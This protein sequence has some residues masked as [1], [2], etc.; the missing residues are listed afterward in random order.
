MNLDEFLGKQTR[1][2]SI[3]YCRIDLRSHR[4]DKTTNISTSYI[5]QTN[6]NN[7]CCKAH[8]NVGEIVKFIIS[9][10][11]FPTF[12]MSWK[13]FMEVHKRYLHNLLVVTVYTQ[14]KR[15]P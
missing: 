4:I 10:Y 14:E 2:I 12:I 1:S 11:P 3:Y 9:S 7:S 15:E 13:L 8:D 5:N 6:Q